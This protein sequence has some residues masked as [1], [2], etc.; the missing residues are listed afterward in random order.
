MCWR[1]IVS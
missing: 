1:T